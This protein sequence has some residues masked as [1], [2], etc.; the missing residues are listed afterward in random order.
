[1][2]TGLH[3]PRFHSE[4]SSKGFFHSLTVIEIRLPKGSHIPSYAA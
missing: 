2:K 3:K 4:V 1:M